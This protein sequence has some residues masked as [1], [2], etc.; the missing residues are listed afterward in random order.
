MKSY[1]E[2]VALRLERLSNTDTVGVS[3]NAQ[4]VVLSLQPPPTSGHALIAK[5]DFQVNTAPGKSDT[6]QFQ[7]WLKFAA[8]QIR[9]D[10]KI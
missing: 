2:M 4:A 10:L 8:F 9:L 6:L 7:T 5:L 1:L 3:A